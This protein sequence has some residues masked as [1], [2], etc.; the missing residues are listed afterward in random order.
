MDNKMETYLGTDYT[1]NY[2]INFLNYWMKTTKPRKTNDLDCLYKEGNL[3]ADTI[4]SFW[5][6]LKFVLDCLNPD[7]HFYKKDKFGSDPHKFLKKIKENINTYLPTDEEVV[8]KLYEFAKLA[9][10]KANVMQWPDG[11][12]SKI[13]TIRYKDFYDQMP[14]L[15]YNCFSGGSY[16]YIFNNN[17]LNLENWIRNQKLQMF[18]CNNEISQEKIKPLIENIRANEG[19]WLTDKNEIIE[20]LQ[21]YIYILE[22]R[23]S[24]L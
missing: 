12:G 22:E 3:D 23:L 5:T 14:P 4:F 19:K 24:Q 9:E 18:F 2:I 10:T 13:Q 21:N 15:L 7:E 1:G 6:P 16:S 17:N 20:M 8:K 11:K